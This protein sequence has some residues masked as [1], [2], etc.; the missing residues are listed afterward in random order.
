[1]GWT[2]RRQCRESGKPARGPAYRERRGGG[3]RAPPSVA[4]ARRGE[5]A[6][7]PAPAQPEQF[8]T[9]P[10][11]GRDSAITHGRHMRYNRSDR[12]ACSISYPR[13]VRT[14]PPRSN[15]RARP[16]K[17]KG[18]KTKPRLSRTQKPAHMSL[19]EWQIELRRQFGREQKFR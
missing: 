10:P 7:L 6:R 12:L 18:E 2:S 5:T 3:T 1:P 19:E 15:L 17:K 8:H 14:M 4:V 13:R 16:G 9:H 11:G